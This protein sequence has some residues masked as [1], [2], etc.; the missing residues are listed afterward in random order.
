M[1]APIIIATIIV[2]AMTA[3]AATAY[4]KNETEIK[5]VYEAIEQVQDKLESIE[6]VQRSIQIDLKRKIEKSES[7]F[8]GTKWAKFT[9]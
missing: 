1:K 6:Q 9:R 7:R 4:Y 2:T 5:P 3:S 8:A